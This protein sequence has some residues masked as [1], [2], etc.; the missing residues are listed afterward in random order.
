MDNEET[1]QTNGDSHG[2]GD[3]GPDKQEDR[4]AGMREIA[5]RLGA[6]GNVCLQGAN[7]FIT[8]RGGW[9]A[10]TTAQAGK[11]MVFSSSALGAAH[12]PVVIYKE[13]QLTKEDTF[14]TA[15][16][17]IREEQGRLSNQNDIL[18]AEI[19]D[20]Q[21]EVDR[22]KDVEAALRE[23]SETQGSQLD[24]L[25]D[26][27][28]ENKEINNGLREVLKMKCLEEVIGLVL[29]IDNDGSFTIQNREVDRLIIGMR[30]IEE[31]SFDE[32][33]FR[34]EVINCGGNVD[35]VITLIKKMLQG[36]ENEQEGRETECTINLDVD[37]DDYFN[38]NKGR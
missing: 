1:Q 30:L 37:P 19:D 6:I 36:C 5:L 11:G 24:E 2:G 13:R 23:L 33:M 15:L 21:S 28:N 9:P 32:A 4:P 12:S 8:T 3:D 22:M 17:G 25:M 38:K 27:I 29:D 26:L 34:R 10:S 20:L 31:I 7:V 14:R 35:E 16:N 18:S